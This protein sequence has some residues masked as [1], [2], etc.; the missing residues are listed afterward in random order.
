MPKIMLLGAPAVGKTTLIRFMGKHISQIPPYYC[1]TIGYEYFTIGNDKI[2]VWDHGGDPRFFRTACLSNFSDATAG[3][4]I[5]DPSDRD[6][7][8]SLTQLLAELKQMAPTAKLILVSLPRKDKAELVTESDVAEFLA[9]NH[10][11]SS[12]FKKIHLD[13]DQESVLQAVKEFNVFISQECGTKQEEKIAEKPVPSLPASELVSPSFLLKVLAHPAT[14]VAAVVLIV[15]GIAGL[16]FG[17]LGLAGI[18]LGLSLLTTSIITGSAGGSALIGGGL[19]TAGFFASKK[20][21]AP[22]TV[23]GLAMKPV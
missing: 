7:F 17:G 9:K 4:L 8:D 10:M 20:P 3:I 6:S 5:Y 1:P 19:F 21:H 23:S 2:P 12:H 13:G 11:E 16:I 18:G 15:A 22:D 14:K